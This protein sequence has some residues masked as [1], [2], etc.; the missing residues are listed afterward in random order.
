V[1]VGDDLASYLDKT[2]KH[3]L[4]TKDLKALEERYKDIP[5]NIPAT[6]PMVNKQIWDK[7]PKPIKDGDKRDKAIQSL[8]VTALC[9][10]LDVIDTLT[11]AVSQNK[12]IQPEEAEALLKKTVDSANLLTL[13]NR[14]VSLNRRERIKPSLAPKFGKLCSEENPIGQTQ[15]FG[16]NLEERVKTLNEEKDINIMKASPSTSS[17]HQGRSPRYKP[18]E[19]PARRYG[20]SGA[21]AGPSYGNLT[22]VK[23]ALSRL[24]FLGRLPASSS[25]YTPRRQ[26]QQQRQGQK[27]ASPARRPYHQ[28]R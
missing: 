21:G 2:H 6:A 18:Y 1:V 13:E 14:M 23:Q 22:K 24:P 12:A 25:N 28:R 15:L 3:G 9:P 20:S 8:G 16:E 10:L 17:G 27:K 7:L 4:E 26:Q 5:A 19:L 11:E